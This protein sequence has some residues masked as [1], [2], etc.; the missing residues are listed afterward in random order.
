MTVAD[1]IQLA[2]ALFGAAR[3]HCSYRPPRSYCPRAVKVR[4]Y[5]ARKQDRA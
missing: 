1:S 2:I 5:R 4:A 3:R